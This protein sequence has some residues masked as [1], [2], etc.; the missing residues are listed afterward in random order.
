MRPVNRGKIDDL[1]LYRLLVEQGRSQKDA[2]ARFG[3][4]EA[5]I[6]K[7]VKALRINLARHVG[8]ERAKEVADRGL[9]VVAQL[10][11]INRSVQGELQWALTE[12]RKPG[13]DRKGLQEVVV[14]L[15]GE[16]RKQLGLQ[17]EIV[18]TLY[19]LR[20]VEEFQREVLNAIGEVSPETQQ[21]IVARLQEARA[22]RSVVALPD[23]GR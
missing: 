7:R 20:A 21:R 15:A 12:A 14:R 16:V 8:L 9:D 13:V 10:Q 11:Q 3:V 23:G 4:T 2:A 18:R 1:T 19:D 6:S 17:V 5:A 22:L